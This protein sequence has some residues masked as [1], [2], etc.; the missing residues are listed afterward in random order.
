MN[1]SVIRLLSLAAACIAAVGSGC[2]DP[3]RE[4][5]IEALGPNTEPNGPDHRPGQP[6]L[7]CHSAGGPAE[8]KAFAVAGTIYKSSKVGEEG[9]AAVVVQFVDSNGGKPAAEYETGATGNFYVPIEDWPDLKFP[10][11]VALY[12]AKDEPPKQTMKSLINR[13]GSC[14]FCHRPNVD[15]KKT[16]DEEAAKDNSR[17]SAGQIYYP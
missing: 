1:G 14:N 15:P 3:T 11:R 2:T 7:V 8:G 9:A 16:D 13:E 4:R 12:E 10:I 17:S 6:C 5:Q